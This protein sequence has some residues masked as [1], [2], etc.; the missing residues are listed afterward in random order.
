MGSEMCI[1]DRLKN[2]PFFLDLAINQLQDLA[3]RCTFE[4]FARNEPILIEGDIGERLYILESGSAKVF[5]GDSAEEELVLFIML[6]GDYVG[7]IALLD[8]SSRS[9]SVV[10]L[11]PSTALCISKSDF[12]RLLD[13]SPGLARSIILSLTR[14]LREDNKRIRSLALDPVY[15]RL[16]DKLYELA[17][18]VENS[19]LFTLPR[20]FSHRALGAMIGASRKMVS[21]I[22]SDLIVGGYIE[23]QDGVLLITKRLPKDW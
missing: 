20:K 7:D 15:R 5:I 6:P 23:L 18:P 12:Q 13:N 10:A 3:G 19:D 17:V 22:L 9:A 16:R 1:R 8:D 4:Q 21:K 2:V 11:E 14:R